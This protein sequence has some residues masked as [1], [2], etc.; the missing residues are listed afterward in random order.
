MIYLL[1]ILSFCL[2]INFNMAYDP[3]INNQTRNST[4][5]EA[6]Q[7]NDTL[8][9]KL[10]NIRNLVNS[11]Y[12]PLIV[13]IGLIG[14]TLIIIILSNENRLVKQDEKHK[15]KQEL[16][17]LNKKSNKTNYKAFSVICNN[18]LFTKYKL[19]F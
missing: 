19:T 4:N 10:E 18:T 16:Q 5:I 3:Q 8:K 15:N 2:M 14:N 9:I 1:F 13:T 11:Y 12:F 6:E 17:K 7:E